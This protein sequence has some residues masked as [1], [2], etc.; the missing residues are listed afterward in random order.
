MLHKTPFEQRVAEFKAK[1]QR[2]AARE[3]ARRI[4]AAE[5][6]KERKDKAARAKVRMQSVQWKRDLAQVED[7]HAR[8]LPV[9]SLR[10]IRAGIRELL[11]R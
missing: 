8:R 3:A 7:V 10:S 11:E 2:R 1:Q 5:Q 6:D 4:R 9:P